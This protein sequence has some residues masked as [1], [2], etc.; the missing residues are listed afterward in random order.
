MKENN[1]CQLCLEDEAI[2]GNL[3]QDCYD[4]S[5]LSENCV[6]ESILD[7]DEIFNKLVEIEK[8]FTI[9]ECIHECIEKDLED[10]DENNAKPARKPVAYSVHKCL[11]CEAVIPEGRDICPKCEHDLT[12]KIEG[13]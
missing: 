6:V 9:N 8:E 13:E 12:P 5:I 1:I 4:A 3:C 7:E 11:Y 10:Q 2:I